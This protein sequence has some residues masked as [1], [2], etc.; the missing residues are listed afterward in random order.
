MKRSVLQNRNRSGFTLVEL[1]VVLGILVLLAALVTQRI[2]GTQKKTDISIT[3][4]Q[5]AGFKG[6][7]ERYSIEMRDLP[8][9]EQ[10]LRALVAAP[11]AAEDGTSSSQWDGPYLGSDVLPKDPW[12]S[13]YQYAYPPVNGTG[14]YPDIWSL[15][16]DAMDGT[17]DDICSWAT[18]N[19][20]GEGEG[21][22]E[23]DGFLDA[24]LGR[25]MEEAEF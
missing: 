15:G 18:T 13:D 25:E 12:G 24:D 20:E 7:L 22:V 4:T 23:D 9:T 11:S 10:G 8:T 14:K 17:E 6:A 3:K 19:V 21:A 1:L 2:L 5:I 16:P